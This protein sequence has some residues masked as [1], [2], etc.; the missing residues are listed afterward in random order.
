MKTSFLNDL[1]SS[2][3]LFIDH[4]ICFGAE[5]FVNI[6]SGQL[7]SSY[8][9]LYDYK[10]I[11]QSSYRQWVA[12][13]SITGVGG[14]LPLSV[15]SGN[16]EIS[17]GEYGLK[18][19]YGM[20]RVFFDATGVNSNL[21]DFTAN[22]A[23][24]EFNVFLTSLDEASLILQE[25]EYYSSFTTGVPVGEQPYP[26]IYVKHFYG[27]NDP[28]AFG[29]LD[30]STYDFRCTILSDNAFK[31]DTIGSVLQD[32]SRKSFPV[33]PS[34]GIPFTVYGDYKDATPYNYFQSCLDFGD[35]LAYINDVSVS[36]F[37]EKIN[38]LIK[39]NVWGGFVDFN[40][41]IIR[42]PRENI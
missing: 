24:K 2:F 29:G 12:V 27:K 41:S 42:M 1:S 31:L 26:L 17:K 32:S 18:I 10:V 40:V 36:K 33:L 38:K 6:E 5:G 22:F 4:E 28:F 21:S 39:D 30:E 13:G 25:P 35:R 11:Y 16:Y 9:P 14:T 7:Y 19:D 20:G 37:D 23:R 3:C 34:S 15:N 8:D